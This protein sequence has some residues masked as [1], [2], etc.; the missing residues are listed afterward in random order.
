MMDDYIKR[1]DAVNAVCELALSKEEEEEFA[2]AIE[3]LPG[4]EVVP[5]EDG[6]YIRAGE[7]SA[8]VEDG[9]PVGFYRP[10][11]PEESEAE[12]RAEVF[13]KMA[14][15]LGEELDAAKKYIIKNALVLVPCGACLYKD[16]TSDSEHCKNCTVRN[17]HFIFSAEKARE[18]E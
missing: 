9:K 12:H 1:A 5:V 10:D 8:I 2:E 15:K 3:N 16:E 6:R 17:L 18:E 4:V 13:E 14:F 11:G 7:V